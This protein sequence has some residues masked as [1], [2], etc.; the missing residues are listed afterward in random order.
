MSRPRT[1]RV[2]DL[3]SPIEY[4][5]GLARTIEV[6]NPPGTGFGPQLVRLRRLVPVALSGQLQYD[7]IVVVSNTLD[8][9]GDR[10]LAI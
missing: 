6:E 5:A 1:W 8:L 10:Q 4:D 3:S 2:S 9:T 7:S